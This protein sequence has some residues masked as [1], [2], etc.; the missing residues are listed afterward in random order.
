IVLKEK[1]NQE[2]PFSINS[3]LSVARV[4]HHHGNRFLHQRRG[5]Q[6]LPKFKGTCFQSSSSHR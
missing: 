6:P 2:L 3:L 5:I 4:S 1:L